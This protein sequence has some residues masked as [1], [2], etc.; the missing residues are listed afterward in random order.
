[1]SRVTAYVAL[2]ANLGDPV[3]Q[4]RDGLAA[5]ARLP[6]T[7]VTAVSPF[8]RSAA[9]GYRDQPDFVNAVAA[10]DTTLAPR[11]LLEALLAIEREHGRVRSFLNAPR[12]LDLDIVLYGDRRVVEDGLEIPHPRMHERAFVVVPLADIAPDVVVPGRGAV[13]RLLHGIDRASLVP[14]DAAP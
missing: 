10:L 12:T 7:R 11:A 13:A 4:L 5:L 14:V 1:M 9:V 6:D 8:Y 2:G 3:A